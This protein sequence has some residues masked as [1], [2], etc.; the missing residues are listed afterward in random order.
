MRKIVKG[1]LT[2]S[3]KDQRINTSGFVG[4]VVSVPA[5]STI[6]WQMNECGCSLLWTL[7]CE[8]QIVFTC[9]EI[10]FFLI[11]FLII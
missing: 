7:K 2:F 1:Q 4:D 10:I 6:Y 5:T 3:A 11:F 9:P 8:F